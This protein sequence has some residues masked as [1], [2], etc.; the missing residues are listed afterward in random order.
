MVYYCQGLTQSISPS[1]ASDMAERS[2]AR[3]TASPP[4]SC[5]AYRAAVSPEDQQVRREPV[6]TDYLCSP[7]SCA[8]RRRIPLKV[9][10]WQPGA[11]FHI[12]LTLS[13]PRASTHGSVTEHTLV[14]AVVVFRPGCAARYT[15]DAMVAQVN[16]KKGKYIM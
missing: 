7:V 16:K 12:S 15:H 13:A 11:L 3:P 10:P 6:R 4:G 5:S 1:S 2:S 14:S 9:D 8:R